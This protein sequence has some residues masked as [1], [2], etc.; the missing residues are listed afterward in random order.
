LGRREAAFPHRRHGPD[1]SAGWDVDRQRKNNREIRRDNV[2][3]RAGGPAGLKAEDPAPP[4]C[5]RGAAGWGEKWFF[6]S[7]GKGPTEIPLFITFL[8]QMSKV[9]LLGYRLTLFLYAQKNY[10]NFSNILHYLERHGMAVW[11]S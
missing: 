5:L 6:C 2:A 1:R 10:I 7:A 8:R 3:G 4:G 9:F 11:L